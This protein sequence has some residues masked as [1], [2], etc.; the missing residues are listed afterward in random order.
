MEL[1]QWVVIT[2]KRQ[3]L[4]DII[5]IQL[6][7]LEFVTITTEGNED[8]GDLTS[9]KKHTVDH[10]IHQLVEYLQVGMYLLVTIDNID[11]ITIVLG[12]CNRFW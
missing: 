11:Y 10:L 12:R 6:N 3:F 4:E 9:S 8:F 2:N 5:L 1:V 7:A